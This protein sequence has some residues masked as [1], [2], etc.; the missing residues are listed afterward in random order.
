M[1]KLIAMAGVASRRRAEELIT[2]GRVRV[3]GRIVKELGTKIDPSRQRIAVD[4]H[5]IA[6]DSRPR[7]Y[8]LLHKPDGVVSSAEEDVDDRGR[9]TVRSLLRGIKERLYP[10]GRLDYHSRGLII[11]TNDGDFA[12]HLT[13][14]RSGVVKTYHAKF[15]GRLE[16]EDLDHLRAGVVLE[17]GTKTLPAVEVVRIKQ[18]ESNDWIQIGLRQG[19]YRQIRR[20]G[21][22]I[23]H[24]VL[25]LI[26]VGIGDIDIDELPEGQYRPLSTA[27]IAMLRTPTAATGLDETAR[28]K[29]KPRARKLVDD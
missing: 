19:L 1:Q 10:V 4:G 23:G 11:L 6:L 2:A 25:K 20:M 28:T 21:D 5:A 14:P 8:L 15:Q 27:E 22:A 17:D 24:P 3:D 7:Y 9:P 12:A 16:N 29:A 18:T 26:R 13:H